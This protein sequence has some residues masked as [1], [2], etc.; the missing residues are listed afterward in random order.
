MNTDQINEVWEAAIQMKAALAEVMF[1]EGMK[2]SEKD[3]VA[4]ALAHPE[5]FDILIRLKG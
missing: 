2:P 4:V 5:K 1:A 3:M